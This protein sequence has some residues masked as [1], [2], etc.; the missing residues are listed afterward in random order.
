MREIEFKAKRGCD[1]VWVYGSYT[2]M[3]EDD[4]N[5][6]LRTKPHKI[7]HRIW[8]WEPG[9]WDMG[10]YVNYEVI[11]ETV[12][13]WTILFDKN[14]TKLYDGDKFQYRKH[15]GYFL[16]DFVGVVKFKNGSFGFT[17]IG[18]ASTGYFVPFSKFD[19]LYEDFL[20]HIEII[21]NIHDKA[22]Q[23]QTIIDMMR[24]DEELGLYNE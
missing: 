20:D 14:K 9:D 16:D 7:Y 11:P 19:E 12:C 5:E 17:V 22:H 1:G 15:D 23:K 10:G 4:H 21:G 24:G 6:C 13:Q 8:Q 2:A 18:E 3:R